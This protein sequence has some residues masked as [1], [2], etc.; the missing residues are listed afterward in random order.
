MMTTL[1]SSEV[2][3]SRLEQ[4]SKDIENESN[5]STTPESIPAVVVPH[6]WTGKTPFAKEVYTIDCSD[7]DMTKLPSENAELKAKILSTFEEI[8]LVLLE[9]TGADT[10]D[11]QDALYPYIELITGQKMVYEGGANPRNSISKSFYEVGA[12][13][14]A[15]LHYHHEMAYVTHSTTAL[16]FCARKIPP[17]ES[18]GFTLPN[19]IT[20]KKGST[21]VSW[22]DGA[23]EEL[24]KTPLGQKLKEKGIC[25]VRRL[26]DREGYQ[27]ESEN[28]IYNHW[29]KSF[30][31]ETPEEAEEECRK[32]NLVPEWG[33][34]PRGKERYLITK[35]FTSAF[36]YSPKQDKNVLYSS[37]AD[38]ANWFDFWPGINHIPKEE[39]DLT[40]LFGDETEFT[41]EERQQW[42]DIYDMFG[43]PVEWNVGDAALVCNWRWAH[44]RPGYLLDDGEDRELGVVLGTPFKKVG[45]LPNKW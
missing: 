4:K 43:V 35:F 19:G 5:A 17:P 25:Y 12:P 22:N 15:H 26:T 40:L 29:Q 14:C 27:G 10:S 39:R 20:C 38:D 45:D 21:F 6:F 33:V 7:Y 31:V 16:G 32:Q 2:I 30:L 8:G 44:G 37:I 18:I 42:A 34:D 9:N 13:G 28:M 24:L 36:E 23:T 41:D 11:K 1:A 3:S